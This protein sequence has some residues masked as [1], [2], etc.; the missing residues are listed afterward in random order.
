MVDGFFS[1]FD[2]RNSLLLPRRSARDAQV[3]TSK[4]MTL[5]AVVNSSEFGSAAE[6]CTDYATQKQSRSGYKPI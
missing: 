2:H 3:N 5:A 6:K 1:C 4:V